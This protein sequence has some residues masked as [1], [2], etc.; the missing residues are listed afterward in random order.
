M[1]YR[2]FDAHCDTIGEILDKDK[3]LSASDLHIDLKRALMPKNSYVQVFAACAYGKG[4]LERAVNLIDRYFLE[5]ERNE[6]IVHCTSVSEI[7]KISVENKICSLLGIEGADAI[8]SLEMLRLFYRLGVRILTLT[9]NYKN[10]ISDGI[11]EKRGAGLTDFGV[12]IIKE[13]NRIGMAIDVSHLS[14]KGFW[15]VC[16]HSNKPFIASHSN[17]KAICK[18]KRNL[19]DE[20]IREIIRLGGCIGINFYPVFLTDNTYCGVGDIIKHIE[21]ILSLGGENNLG[22]GSDFDGIDILPDGISGVEDYEKLINELLKLGYKESFVKKICSEN[23]LN[24]LDRIF[25]T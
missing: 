17:A 8:E 4:A 3:K 25:T 22:F 18:N 21:H 6:S 16:E 14:E 2:I 13:M 15:D 5:I 11:L 9:W 7:R 12:S 20:Q 24:V 19:S 1:S 23:F 10:S